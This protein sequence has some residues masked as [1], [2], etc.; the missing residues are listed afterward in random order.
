M[1]N[2]HTEQSMGGEVPYRLFSSAQ[3]HKKTSVDMNQIV[4]SKD[5][6][7]ICL[8][9][10]RYDAAVQEQEAGTTS[11]LNRYGPWEKRQAPGNFTYPSH[12]AMFAGFLPCDF[13]AKSLADR[14]MLFFPKQIG[15][16]K[17]APDGSFGF[18]GSTVMEGL[19]KEGY[20]TWCVG[21]VSF[22]DKRTDL[23]KVFPG[24]SKELLE[25]FLCLSGE[26][27]HQKSG[28]F[29]SEKTVLCQR[30]AAAVSL[31]QCGCHSLS[32]LFLSG[33]GFPGQLGEP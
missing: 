1:M 17:K 19:E 15:M 28:G 4:G 5:I 25:S 10:L 21:G 2:N 20:E 26:R 16:G 12:H 22:F 3:G 27:Q 31:S 30:G 29:Y 7:F 33:E 13:E 32:E 11:V 8:D 24:F 14:E 9:T 6:L 23:G 18:S